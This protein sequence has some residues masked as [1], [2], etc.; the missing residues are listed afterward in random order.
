MKKLVQYDKIY[1]FA[2]IVPLSAK[3]GENLDVLMKMVEKYLPEGPKYFPDDM[4]S[5]RETSCRRS[6][7]KSS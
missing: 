1:K 7:V 3:T 2:E 5:R 4:T 6:S